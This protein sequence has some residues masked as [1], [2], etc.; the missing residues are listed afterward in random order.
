MWH[1]RYL[2]YVHVGVFSDE[3]PP[4]TCFSNDNKQ[5]NKSPPSS[6][7][8][9]GDFAEHQAKRR[10]CPSCLT[11]VVQ[12]SASPQSIWHSFFFSV[13]MPSECMYVLIVMIQFFFLFGTKKEILFMAQPST[14]Q[15]CSMFYKICTYLL[16][17][18]YLI[19]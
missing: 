18:N 14:N 3:N 9:R 13:Q 7:S 16:L 10:L 5:I 2:K 4:K 8:V 12:Q 17:I 1:F 19:R 11:D 15:T 6:C